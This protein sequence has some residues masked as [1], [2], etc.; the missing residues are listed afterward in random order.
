MKIYRFFF[1]KNVLLFLCVFKVI[2]HINL[3][4]HFP[5]CTAGLEVVWTCVDTHSNGSL[6][7]LINQNLVASLLRNSRYLPHRCARAARPSLR[8]SD[9]DAAV[10]RSDDPAG[11]DPPAP[12]ECC[13][14]LNNV[15]YSK[16]TVRHRKRVRI[17]RRGCREKP[18]LKSRL[19]VF[20][21]WGHTAGKR[22]RPLFFNF[23]NKSTIFRVRK[24]NGFLWAVQ[25]QHKTAAIT[26]DMKNILLF[27]W[28]HKYLCNQQAKNRAG[29]VLHSFISKQ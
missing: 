28:K 25:L 2:F 14:G 27:W 18:P 9:S 3:E 20:G 13:G 16:V 6:F 8:M 24:T 5:R 4:L 21:Y 17:T 23:Q 1:L 15:D 19:E 12:L 7:L 22:Q 10:V 11:N 29:K 26:C